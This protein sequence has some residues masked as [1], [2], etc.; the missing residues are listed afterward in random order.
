MRINMRNSYFVLNHPFWKKALD[1]NR[2]SY[3]EPDIWNRIAEIFKKPQNW[4]TFK[5]KMKHYY[6]NDFSQIQIY[7]K[8]VDLIV[9][10]II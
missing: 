4:S 6:L 5:H 7:Q 3:I 1:Q 10:I 2:L 8:L 9:L